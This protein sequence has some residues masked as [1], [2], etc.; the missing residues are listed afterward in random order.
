MGSS[1]GAHGDSGLHSLPVK[2]KEKHLVIVIK[3]VVEVDATF[4]P[5]LA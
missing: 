3:T 2:I 4:F 1:L 5:L